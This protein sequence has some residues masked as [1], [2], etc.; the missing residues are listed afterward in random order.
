M[1]PKHTVEIGQIPQ[2]A[3]QSDLNDRIRTGYK[4]FPI[5][6]IPVKVQVIG[7]P[8][9]TVHTKHSIALQYILPQIMAECR[10]CN[11][12]YGKRPGTFGSSRGCYE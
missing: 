4:P 8:D 9:Q 10:Y 2:S 12:S 5:G 6:M 7:V 1:L 3:F 11:P